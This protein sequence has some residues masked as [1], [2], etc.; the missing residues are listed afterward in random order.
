MGR[1]IIITEKRRLWH[2]DVQSHE[3]DWLGVASG[4]TEAEAIVNAVTKMA[5]KRKI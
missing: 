1:V 3:G 4:K 5:E 2:A